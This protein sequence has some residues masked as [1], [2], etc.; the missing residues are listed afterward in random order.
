[1]IS[2]IPAVGSKRPFGNIL[3]PSRQEESD[4]VDTVMK[5]PRKNLNAPEHVYGSETVPERLTEEDGSVEGVGN[6]MNQF[7]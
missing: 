7:N 3:S 6:S 1:M 5:R 2:T 4:A